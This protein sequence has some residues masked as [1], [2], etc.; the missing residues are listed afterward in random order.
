M[1]FGFQTKRISIVEPL[2][3]MSNKTLFS[4]G[5]PLVENEKKYSPTLQPPILE[6]EILDFTADHVEEL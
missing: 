2:D 4:V 5:R 1:T 6:N 3:G